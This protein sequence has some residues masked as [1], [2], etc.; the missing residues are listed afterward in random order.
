MGANV[1]SGPARWWIGPVLFRFTSQYG[2]NRANPK[3][4]T[5]AKA[6]MMR[7]RA[8]ERFIKGDVHGIHY[9]VSIF[10]ATIVL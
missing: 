1:P 8:L 2:Y 7:M 10:I 3:F 6:A 5:N 9:A 4:R